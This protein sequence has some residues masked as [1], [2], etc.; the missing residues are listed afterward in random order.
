MTRCALHVCYSRPQQERSETTPYRRSDLCRVVRRLEGSCFLVGPLAASAESDA[1]LAPKGECEAA[2][3][4]LSFDHQHVN[5]HTCTAT[6]TL[7]SIVKLAPLPNLRSV[8]PMIYGWQ[9][10]VTHTD[11]A[12][13]LNANALYTFSVSLPQI[14]FAFAFLVRSTDTRTPAPCELDDALQCSVVADLQKPNV[15]SIIVVIGIFVSFLALTI[16]IV[17][18][19]VDFP[20]QVFAISLTILHL[21]QLT[22]ITTPPSLLPTALSG[23]CDRGGGGGEPLLPAT[24]GG[25]D[26]GVG[27]Q[28][29]R[30]GRR[31]REDDA[32]SVDAVRGEQNAGDGGA[33]AGDTRCDKAR[34]EGDEEEAG[35]TYA[36][37]KQ[38]SRTCSRT[39]AMSLPFPTYTPSPPSCRYIEHFMFQQ[40]EQ[41]RLAEELRAKR[42]AEAEAGRAGAAAPA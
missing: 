8:T 11:F 15:Q 4:S 37:S 12:G 24:G 39:A 28:A 23:V 27:G 17:N 40:I 3:H 26:K 30:R 35:V 1:T 32:Q 2:A 19:L 31:E 36:A 7:D 22:P 38:H 14:L 33:R 41:K 21:S 20:A 16:S 13:I 18:I 42:Q 29:L 34:E 5:L 6:A 25:G 10:S 9:P